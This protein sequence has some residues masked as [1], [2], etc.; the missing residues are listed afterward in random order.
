[1]YKVNKHNNISGS[2]TAMFVQCK[3]DFMVL[4]GRMYVGDV[5]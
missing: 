2:C 1:M 3:Y 5:I 4:C